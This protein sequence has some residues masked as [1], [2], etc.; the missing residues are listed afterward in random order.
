MTG[1]WGEPTRKLTDSEKDIEICKSF[2]FLRTEYRR[3]L[4]LLVILCQLPGGVFLSDIESMG[5]NRPLGD[6][7]GFLSAIV[8]SSEIE[9][10]K[11][12]S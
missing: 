11:E 1:E 2:D 7:K 10:E 9:N 5:L 8:D 4:S 3:E 12:S 6:W